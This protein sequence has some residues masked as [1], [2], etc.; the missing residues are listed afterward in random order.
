MG[1]I[2]YTQDA[3][4]GAYQQWLMQQGAQACLDKRIIG[5]DAPDCGLQA[6]TIYAQAGSLLRYSVLTTL[7]SVNVSF[8]GQF[9]TEAKMWQNVGQVVTGTSAGGID[10]ITQTA[11]AGCYKN[12]VAS[13]GTA[14]V[15]G[16]EVYVLAELG[17]TNN[18]EFVPYAVLLSGYVTTNEPLDSG[19]GPRG[20]PTPSSGGSGGSCVCPSTF[21]IRAIDGVRSAQGWQDNYTPASGTV[22]RV[23]SIVGTATMGGTAGN[24]DV[25]AEFIAVGAG[26]VMWIRS[27]TTITAGQSASIQGMV[28]R[29]PDLTVGTDFY[30]SIPA[31][32]W[33]STEYQVQIGIGG[34]LAG[35]TITDGFVIIEVRS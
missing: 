21:S 8:F 33:W 27:P 34:F 31:S 26:P 17:R 28:D 24:R 4:L 20:R 16:T 19:G 35:D 25:F 14:S 1:I 22:E 18:G 7:T 29:G 5:Q 6:G 11:T 30:R 15:S 32:L 23:A 3:V 10:R 2:T 9:Q 12:M 13:V